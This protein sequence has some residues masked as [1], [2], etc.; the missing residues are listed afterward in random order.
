MKKETKK[1]LI[2]VLCIFI[3]LIA[4]VVFVTSGLSQREKQL[5]K[6]PVYTTAIVID[7]YVGTKVREFVKYE[8]EAD[9]KRYIGHQQYFPKLEYVNVGDTCEVIYSKT[10]PEISNLLTNEDH[11]LKIRRK[12]KTLD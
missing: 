11:S 6:D 3:P 10:N 9:G 4:F 7:T 5:E 1:Q 2:T 8:F 12:P